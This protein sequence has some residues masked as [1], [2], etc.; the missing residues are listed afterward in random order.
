MLGSTAITC[1][2]ILQ[3]L[4]SY[5]EAMRYWKHSLDSL[6]A[7]DSNT[8]GRVQAD[9][10]GLIGQYAHG[11]E[12]SHHIAYL[13]NYVGKAWKTQEKVRQIM[14]EMYQDQPDGLSGNEDC[15]QMSAWYVLSAMG[16]YP[17]TPAQNTYA[18]G[19]PI[20]DKATINLESGKQFIIEARNNSRQN[21]YIQRATFNDQI[22]TAS[23]LKHEDIMKGGVLVF[24][25]GNTPN[26]K[27]GS[28]SENSPS[29]AI[30]EHLI[31]PVP[32]VSKGDRTF[33]KSTTI[34]LGTVLGENAIHYTLNGSQPSMESPVY[35]S[36]IPISETTTLRAFAAKKN[37]Q[38][39]QTVE[40]KFF[41]IPKNRKIQ[42]FEE[43]APQYSGGGDL[44]L[45][46]FIRAPADFRTGS[47]QG[48]EG[49]DME[50]IVD[51]GK[52]QTINR[53]SLG[54]LRDQNSWIF[55]PKTVTFF[56]SNNGRD[57]E[58][59]KT[60]KTAA[61]PIE[62]IEGSEIK[63]YMAEKEVSARYVK[64]VAKNRG[65]VPYWHKGAGG[66]AWVFMDEIMV[67]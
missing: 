5:W 20:F 45:I 15:G 3:V 16:F 38:K 62:M 27:W 23:Y 25:M 61:I 56:T 59:L 54:C 64:V 67:E 46:D 57:F 12:P 55:L 13:Y 40:A 14:S 42:L 24:E 2:R 63:E 34:E 39:S 6:F 44:A 7:A 33:M 29:S 65:T 22:Y 36:P 35:Q 48:Y 28:G 17:V 9:I 11:N 1:H 31:V 66:K 52:E 41:K 8:S 49:V 53:L 50:A 58:E 10:T 19:S 21:K 26:E 37:G 51:L 60:I 47:W 4:F 43:Y 18:I 30:A 32:F